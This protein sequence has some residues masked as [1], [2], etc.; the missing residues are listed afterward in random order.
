M[1]TLCD[2]SLII[3]THKR[4]RLL[5]RALTSIE[6]QSVSAEVIVVSDVVDRETDHVC[7]ALLEQRDI[8][9]RRNGLP[10]PS[11]SRNLALSVASGRYVLF[12]DDDDALHAGALDALIAHPLF[13]QGASIYFNCSIVKERRP[14]GGDVEFISEEE[15]DLAG[16]LTDQVHVN[17]P[18]G[19]A[20][21]ALRGRRRTQGG[22]G[23][24]DQAGKIGPAV[25]EVRDFDDF[26]AG[27]PEI[28]LHHPAVQ[29]MDGL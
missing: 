9:I 3:P 1:S 28:G 17:K 25:F 4:P 12:L 21:A 15:L 26:K 14:A 11:A 5:T 2:F 29:G 13:H 6:R 20:F 18:G 24:R 10:G 7:S 27:G 8:Y 22:V 19:V 23:Q 16:R